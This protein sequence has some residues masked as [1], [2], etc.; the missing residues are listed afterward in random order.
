M[1]TRRSHATPNAKFLELARK[2]EL[3]KKLGASETQI[4]DLIRSEVL[5]ELAD[6][7]MERRQPSRN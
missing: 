6:A 2:V 4:N 7:K 5:S 3:L 1:G